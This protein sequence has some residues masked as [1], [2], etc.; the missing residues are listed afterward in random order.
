MAIVQVLFPIPMYAT[1][2]FTSYQFDESS[3]T[4]TLSYSMDQELFFTEKIIFP[5]AH[6]Q[7]ERVDKKLLQE[8]FRRLHIM[9]G[10]SYWKTYMPKNMKIA[11]GDI[12]T[13]EASFWNEVYTKGLGEFFYRNAIDFRGLINFQGSADIKNTPTSTP[14]PE[15]SLVAIGGGKDS[16]V[17]AEMLLSHNE[18]FTLFSV[19]EHKAI[20]D[21]AEIVGKPWIMVKRELSPNIREINE[22]PEVKN[23]HIPITAFNSFVMLVCCVL[24]GFDTIVMSI[25]KSADS[26]NVLFHG[27]EVNH[28]YSKS[29]A[30]ERRFHEFVHTVLTP[31]I[32]YT[33]LLRPFYE[34]KIGELFA[35]FNGYEKGQYVGSERS[36]LQSFASCNANFKLLSEKAKTRWCGT[37]PKCAFVFINLAPFFPKEVM[38]EIFEQ[39][40]LASPVLLETY[41]E[42]LGVSGHKPFE[43]VGTKEEIALAFLYLHEQGTYKEEEAMLMFEAQVLPYLPPKEQMEAEV[44]RTYSL[45]S[46]PHRLRHLFS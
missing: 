24:Y 6:I 12:S 15:A 39:N 11:T 9:G 32:H 5:T 38:L 42:L 33:S 45:E 17:S 3:G 26:G 29:M 20:R 19:H 28:Q 41:G 4:L 22:R 25:E 31:N 36:Y 18:E 7:W 1:F 8:L 35:L 30:F 44:M 34:L 10:V 13:Y 37:C 2:Y 46:I 16:L 23:G 40:M 14:L 27:L 21:T 43:C